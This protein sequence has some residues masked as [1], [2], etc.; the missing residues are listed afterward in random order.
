MSTFETDI[1]G[2]KNGVASDQSAL[3]QNHDSFIAGPNDRILITGATGFVGSRVLQSLLD[4]GFRNFVCFGRS[5]TGLSKIETLAK[6]R[7]A[8]ARIEVLKGNLLSRP[9]C[10]AACKDVRIIFH[11]AAG[12]GEKSFPDAFM[13]SVVA[14]RNLLDASLRHARLRRFV[15]VSSFAVYTNLHKPKG[16][17]LDESCPMEEH[18]ELRGEAYCFAKV[19]QEELLYE[20][21]KNFGIPYVVVRPGNVYGPG[22]TGIVGRVGIDS[23]GVFLHLGGS[24]PIPF[25]YVDNCAEAIV[26]SGLV[27]GVDGEVFNVVDDHAPSSQ[28]FL[29]MYKKNVRRF[30]SIYVPHAVSHALCFLWERYS[31][32]SK[33]QLPPV[34][35]PRRWHSSWKKTRFSNEKLKVRLGW[36]PKVSTE[37][38]L[39]RYFESCRQ[40][41]RHA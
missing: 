9:D 31:Q 39:R 28:Q 16:R 23:F 7:S 29:R 13:N 27:R 38:G 41:G 26:L 20:Y 34:F 18:P 33:G 2:H 40:C 12:T 37:E 3:P 32:W 8:E 36:K 6:L 35:N 24:N 30:K 19:K 10:E 17:L 14:T 1:A 15:L 4:Q 5:S 11:L 21:G 22:K 25:T